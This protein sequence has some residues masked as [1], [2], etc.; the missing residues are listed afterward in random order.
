MEGQYRC[1]E[2]GENLEKTKLIGIRDYAD[3]K[4]FLLTW[5]TSFC[6]INTRFSF[7]LDE[8]VMDWLMGNK[9]N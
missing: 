7:D 2:S 4:V 3:H 9:Y 5:A 6:L 1:S 8:A